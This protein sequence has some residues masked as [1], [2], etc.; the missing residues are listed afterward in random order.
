MAN[1]Y[2]EKVAANA[3]KT[4]LA[5][6]GVDVAG[7][8]GAGL[9]AAA[10]KSVNT[11]TFSQF[12]QTANKIGLQASPNLKVPKGPRG[13]GMIG[14]GIKAP[15]RKRL[16]A[17]KA[18]GGNLQG[19]LQQGVAAKKAGSGLIGKALSFA[20]K[21]PLFAAGA[22]LATG[23]AGAATLGNKDNGNQPMYGGYPQY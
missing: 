1:R 14:S 9:L 7:M 16:D 6:K 20:K 11:G 3:Y 8:S 2:L 12:N 21:K 15:I 10:P 5:G 19:A 18:S 17:I 13:F 4:F 23:L 22:A